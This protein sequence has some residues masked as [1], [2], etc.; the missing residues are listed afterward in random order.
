MPRIALVWK[1]IAILVWH[2]VQLFLIV[3]FEKTYLPRSGS[4]DGDFA[5][6][7]KLIPAWKNEPAVVQCELETRGR[8]AVQWKA[9]LNSFWNG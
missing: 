5:G 1:F 6:A 8:S 4:R 2:V 7:V 3:N 9:L